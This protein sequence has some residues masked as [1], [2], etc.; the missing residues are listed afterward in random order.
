MIG[1]TILHYK[2]LEKLGSG[3]MGIVYLAEDTKLGRKVAIKFLPH[4]ISV[5]QEEKER[6]KIE[7]RASAALSHPNIATIYAIEESEGQTF[8]VLEYIDGV[9][10]KEKIKSGPLPCQEAV[11][12]A[13]Q[14]AEG[15]D[16]SHKA[17]IIHRDIKSQN[18]MV[19][20][21]GK[22]KIMDFGLAKI[23]GGE[24]VTKMGSTVGTISYMSPEQ[25]HGAN[26]DAR[27]DIFSFGVIL[28]EMLTGTMPFRGEHE[29]AIIYSIQNE[30]PQ[31]ILDLRQDVPENLINIVL[32]MLEKDPGKR[33]QKAT[34]IFKDLSKSHQISEL[35]KDIQADQKR[36]IAVMYFENMSS[37]KESDYFC[38]GITEDII[39][40]L[41]K[42]KELK[43]VSRNDVLIYRDKKI[44]TSQIG[45]ALSVSHILEGSVR[46]S[47]NKMRIS[48]QLV[49]VQSGFQ[50]WAERFDRQVE[51][52]FDL[53]NEIS[54]KIV[55]ALKVSLTDSEKES[56]Q[57]NPT[58]NLKA[59]DYYMRGR[60]LVY[61][62]GK[63]NN[64]KAIKMFDKAIS[65]DPNF[66]EAYAGLAEAYSYMFEWYDGNPS[67]L[68]KSIEVNQ[69]ALN[70][71]PTLVEAKF[72]IAM[73]YFYQKRIMEAKR[74]LENIVQ[75]SPKFYP[76][77][78]RLG[79][80]SEV[81][82]DFNSA[83]RYYQIASGLKPHD[84]EPWMHLDSVLRRLGD[85]KSADDAAMKVIEVTAEKLEASQDDPVVMARLAMAYA[86]FKG[87][88]E[89]RAILK[90]LF[91]IDTNDGLVLYYS[92]C[93]YGLLGDK[94]NM[95]I[96]LRRAFD[97]GFKG[98]ANWAK[99][100]TSLDSFREDPEFKE[101]IARSE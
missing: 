63:I 29:A 97:A 78:I 32:K 92:S 12:F 34:D 51:D 41:S 88:E 48:A 66:A 22:V 81:S 76:A 70:L 38:A 100:E 72:G 37:E 15:L 21:E 98:L 62:V 59:Y 101:L 13:I 33:Y 26:V 49:D 85:N 4:N 25:M 86:K 6:F 53:Q 83:L 91:E 9:E 43:V 44:N 68:V 5:T 96:T 50:V 8:I 42:V 69:K 80:I 95:L 30:E 99:T 17:G 35:R 31:S 84:E 87:V 47:G 10:L 52:I 55:Q 73:V 71:N 74:E 18:I 77:F 36:S 16:A 45:E 93:T 7:A 1:S 24:Q 20:K 54:E 39:T 79:M 89:A 75:E 94:R 60:E 14:I 2:V 46:K 67:W 19:T 57:A 27:A 58:D 90:R 56:L 23:K 65:S 64:E 28:F 61:R 11:N 40:D 82:N 3:G